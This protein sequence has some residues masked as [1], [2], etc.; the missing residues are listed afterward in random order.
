MKLE[1]VA[2]GGAAIADRAVESKLAMMQ[3]ALAE[4]LV[5]SRVERRGQALCV[6]GRGVQRATIEDCRLR[7]LGLL[8]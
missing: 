6:N 1:G 8:K 5:V 3:A 2:R 4:T 7:F